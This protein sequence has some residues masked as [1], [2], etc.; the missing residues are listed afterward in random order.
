MNADANVELPF[1]SVIVEPRKHAAFE[2]VVHNVLLRTPVGSPMVIVHGTTNGPWIRQKLK[3]IL[4]ADDYDR[5]SFRNCGKANLTGKEYNRLLKT[6]SFWLALPFS[7]ILV[8]QTD[9]IILSENRDEIVRYF[10]HA[11]VGAPWRSGKVGNGGFSLRDKAYCLDV[12]RHKKQDH[13]NI[14]EDVYFSSFMYH[15]NNRHKPTPT[16]V[17]EEFSI[18]TTF[19]PHPFAVHNCWK[20]LSAQ[21]WS[22]LC[23]A[24]PEL[25][26]LRH[27]QTA[28]SPN[29]PVVARSVGNVG[30]TRIRGGKMRSV[31]IRRRR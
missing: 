12:I 19:H 10:P 29:R 5:L 22:Q 3:G 30:R 18:E 2:F 27:L 4:A 9:S 7:K 31:A 28:C 23:Q 24:H 14:N 25:V 6:A 21:Q 8:F 15:S 16:S 11:Y 20:Y 13:R 17:A 26:R 1:G